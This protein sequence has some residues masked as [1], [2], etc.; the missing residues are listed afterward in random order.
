M[1]S[2]SILWLFAASV[3]A[4]LIA[5][6]VRLGRFWLLI[7]FVFS[8]CNK[9]VQG[10]L[11]E[12]Y[13]QHESKPVD[14][15]TIYIRNYYYEG[16]DGEGFMPVETYSVETDSIGYYSVLI[17]RSAY[18]QVDTVPTGYS[19]LFKDIYVTRKKNRIDL[20]FSPSDSSN[21]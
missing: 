2:S 6:M 5:I 13:V 18:V 14:S 15:I 21:P 16:G 11:I 9:D 7:A 19:S 17:E 1:T 12:G 3:F 4:T 10:V 8:S 20:Q